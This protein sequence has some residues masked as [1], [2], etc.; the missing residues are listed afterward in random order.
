MAIVVA[1]VFYIAGRANPRKQVAEALPRGNVH[2]TSM[3]YLSVHVCTASCLPVRLAARVFIQLCML[4]NDI[5]LWVVCFFGAQEQQRI[6]H[7]SAVP[8]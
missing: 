4:F 3:H 6:K 8:R 1:Y 7:I 5:I 2:G